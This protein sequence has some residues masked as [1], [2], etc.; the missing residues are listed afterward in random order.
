MNPRPLLFDYWE[1][2]VGTELFQAIIGQSD[3]K[4]FHS[5]TGIGGL[6]KLSKTSEGNRDVLEILVIHSDAPA[7]GQLHKFME[8]A[9]Q[10]FFTIIIWEITNPD[11]FVILRGYGFFPVRKIDAEGLTVLGMSWS[12]GLA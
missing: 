9:K 1:P 2:Y 8:Q 12:R 11:M 6:A 5:P 4:L 7:Q 3:H 10:E